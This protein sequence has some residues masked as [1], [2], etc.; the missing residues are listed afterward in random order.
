MRD[1]NISFAQNGEDIVLWR[2]LKDITNGVYLDVGANDPTIM[3]VTRKFYDA[4]WHGIAIEP[5]PEYA[6][7]FRN[8]R[9]RDI[10]YQAVASNIDAPTV[11][12]HL[13]E[14]TGLSTL[15]DDIS[16]E[17]AEAG[18]VVR[19]ITVPV[20]S[21]NSAIEEAGLSESD[22]HFLSIDTEGAEDQVIASLDFTRYRPWIL[23]IEATAPLSTRQVHST[24]ES[25]VEDAGYTFQFF[26]GLSRFY[27][28]NERLDQ[29]GGTVTYS[30]GILD[31]YVEVGQVTLEAE[32]KSVSD[33]RDE[34]T[35]RVAEL[36]A[37]LEEESLRARELARRAES[38]EKEA[39]RLGRLVADLQG[40][41][42]WRI[43]TPLRAAR[44]IIRKR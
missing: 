43:T 10:V 13:I 14:G 22:I 42:S 16:T 41:L 11:D 25:R 8:E 37:R 1:R 38:A 40:T 7:A 12:F 30:A 15:V 20:I 2:A 26:D 35:Q 24:W 4:G 6:S 9:P 36:T 29:L 23:I 28:A 31:D 19:D 33:A 17:H 3:S 32:L 34:A 21:L 39:A 5:N 27:V 18:W 44:R